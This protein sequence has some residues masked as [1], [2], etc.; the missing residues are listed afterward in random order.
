MSE[1]LL[2][3]CMIVRDEADTLGRCLASVN[4]VVDETIV[5]DTGSGDDTAAVARAHGAKIYDFQWTGSFAEAR[6]YSLSKATGAWILWMDADEALEPRD[7]DALRQD[8]RT[9]S[10]Q[11][12]LY[13]E[14]LHYIGSGR[15]DPRRAY[16]MAQHRV[17]P[18][19]SGYAFEG[20]IH[21][22]LIRDGAP[23]ADD[24]ISLIPAI[25]HHFGY[26]DDIRQLKKKRERNLLML[27]KEKQSGCSDPWTDYHIAGEL[28][29]VGSYEDAFAAVNAAIAGALQSGQLPPNAFYRLKYAVLLASGNERGAWPGIDRALAL[30][31]DDVGLR[32]YKGVI[33]S[34][35]GQYGE[36]IK[37]FRTCLTLGERCGPE[38]TKAG[39]GSF[40]AYEFIGR[41]FKL[42]GDSVEANAA[43]RR[44]EAILVDYDET[45]KRLL[46][47]EAGRIAT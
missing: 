32:F 23:A 46:Q 8:V 38:L 1:K 45:M 35:N 16:R 28:N 4:G 44:A 26:M 27:Q 29:G 24:A 25:I 17:F 30:Y 33:L 11:K 9:S 13:A 12:L 40:R 18:S 41:C 10:R 47:I 19:G 22:R 7:A 14:T 36:A 6:N 43:Y 21:E 37:A 31:P 39:I 42:L 34:R 20:A 3:L 2:S 15:P 5:V